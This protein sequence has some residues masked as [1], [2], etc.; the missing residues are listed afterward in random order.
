MQK[1]PENS[2]NNV[3]K[4]TTRIVVIITKKN[5]KTPIIVKNAIV[6]KT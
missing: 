2:L 3:K 6:L 1:L 4:E 5:S